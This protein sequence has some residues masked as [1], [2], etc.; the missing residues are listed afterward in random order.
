MIYKGYR[1]KAIKIKDFSEYYITDLGMVYS[2]ILQHNKKGRI[3][4]IKQKTQKSGYQS[5]CLYKN[6]QKKSVLVHRLVAEAFIPNPKNKPQVNH[7]NGIRSDNRV[8]NLEWISV[9][10]NIKHAFCK[11]GRIPAWKGKTGKLHFSSKI[12]FQIKNNK[13]LKKFYGLHDAERETGIKS[14]HISDCCLGK[15]KT[16]GGYNWK[17]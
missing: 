5:V 4:L 17:Y 9:S 6:K 13:I 12:V 7:K 3:K 8:E 15:R 16:A 11:L 1:M 14:S 10:E 2:R